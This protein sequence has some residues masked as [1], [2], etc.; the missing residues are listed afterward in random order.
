MP[1][2]VRYNGLS[3]GAVGETRKASVWSA[4]ISSRIVCVAVRFLEPDA[5]MMGRHPIS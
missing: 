4:S 1:V 3:V 5:K 2:Q